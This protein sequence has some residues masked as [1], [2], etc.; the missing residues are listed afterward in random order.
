MENR[1]VAIVF[2]CGATNVRVIAIDV[3]GEILASRSVPNHTL[4]D[5]YHAGGVI[6]DVDQIWENLC[7]ASTEVAGQIDPSRVAGITVTSFGVDGAFVDKYGN[8][9]YP[10]VSWKCERTHQAM[11]NIGK[12]IDPTKLYNISGVYPYAFNTIYKLVWFKENQPQ[13]IENAHR[14]LFFPSLLIHRLTGEMRNDVTMAGTSMTMDLA[15]RKLSG[16]IYKDLGIDVNLLGELAEPGEK[17]GELTKRAENK[18]GLPTGTPVY[19]TGH[20]T[21]FA[22]FGSGADLGQPVLSTGTWEI[23]MVRS[24]SFSTTPK[25]L[26]KKL[27]N[28]ID[29]QKKVVNIGQNWLG[30]GVLEWFSRNFY[31]GLSGKKLYETMIEQASKVSPGSHG[32][33]VSPNFFKED[34]G[35]RGGSITG[36]TLGTKREEIY[37]AILESLAFRLKEG[38]GIFEKAGSFKADKIICVGGGSQNKLWNQIRADVCNIPIQTIAQ[39]ETTVLGA[40]LFVF[41]GSGVFPSVEQARENINYK[42]SWVV[43]SENSAVYKKLYDARLG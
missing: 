34:E 35:D 26:E 22:I 27:T 13:I 7:S 36:F 19:F 43:P 18:T 15:S 9:L 32:M 3:Y 42:P 23:L 33:R 5:P 2:D 17:A 21:Q 14:F 12:Y 1:D 31:P 4:P 39:K 40:S 28:E 37:R 38:V 25:E 29:P 41:A 6:W 10:V 8:M 20:D 30:S 24:K 11:K 16:Q